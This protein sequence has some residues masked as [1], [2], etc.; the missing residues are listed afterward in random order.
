M[1]PYPYAPLCHTSCADWC[2]AG[3]HPEQ[4][5]GG[6]GAGQVP[7]WGWEGWGGA[8]PR[9]VGEGCRARH[10]PLSPAPHPVI[11]D[12]HFASLEELLRTATN[13]LFCVSDFRRGDHT[14]P[15]ET[16]R[17]IENTQEKGGGG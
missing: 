6:G 10:W 11:H 13:I 16:E 15:P 4:Q 3:L 12:G 7:E 17:G 2:R 5:Q 8:G 14:N 1:L 9:A